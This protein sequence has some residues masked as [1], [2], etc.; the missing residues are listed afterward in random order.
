MVLKYKNGREML[1]SLILNTDW[2]WLLYGNN[3]ARSK[4]SDSMR[5]SYSE[6]PNLQPKLP[7]I[8]PPTAY[9]S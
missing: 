9:Y 1:H 6:E 2:V 7:Q 4:L 3:V 8:L 5:D